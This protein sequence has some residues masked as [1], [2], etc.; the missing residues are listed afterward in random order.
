MAEVKLEP[1]KSSN[2][3]AV[4]YD[5]ETQELQVQF[6]GGS[7]YAYDSVPEEIHLELIGNGEGIGGRFHKKVKDKFV[8]RKL[9]K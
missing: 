8:T 1:V 3:E 6:K 2:I 4:G 9:T 5:A 7:V